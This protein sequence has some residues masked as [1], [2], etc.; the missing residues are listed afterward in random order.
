[1]RQKVGKERSQG[2]CHPLGH[3][4]LLPEL[5]QALLRADASGALQSKLQSSGAER[6]RAPPGVVVTRATRRVAV[7]QLADQLSNHLLKKLGLAPTPRGRFAAWAHRPA[8]LRVATGSAKFSAAFLRALPSRRDGRAGASPREGRYFS[9][10]S[11]DLRWRQPRNYF[12]QQSLSARLGKSF[13]IN[14]PFIGL[15]SY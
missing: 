12:A 7:V 2:D 8:T 1:M 11:S 6:H 15:I 4:P 13:P 9:L 14:S 3:P 10:R 5:G